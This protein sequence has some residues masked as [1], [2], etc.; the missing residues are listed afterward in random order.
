MNYELREM[1]PEDGAQVLQIFEEGIAGGNATFDREVPTWEY[2][3]KNHFFR[4]RGL[5]FGANLCPNL[6]GEQNW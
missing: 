6:Y 5:S 2:W 1:L 4:F 3:D